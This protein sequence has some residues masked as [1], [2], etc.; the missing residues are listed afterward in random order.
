MAR[1]P[2]V[3]ALPP[4]ATARRTGTAPPQPASP[5]ASWL[6]VLPQSAKTLLIVFIVLGLITEVGTPVARSAA[7]DRTTNSLNVKTAAVSEW[8]NA[9]TTLKS[10]MAQYPT[11]NCRQSLSCYTTAD[12]HFAA[13]MS[14]FATQVQAIT[15]PPAAADD[16]N[17]VVADAKQA[18]QEFTQLSHVSDIGLYQ[19]TY[20][21][22][23]VA[24]E[25]QRFSQ[26]V[27]TFGTALG[28]S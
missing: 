9:F 17:T 14:T 18:A 11:N 6:L 2:P 20:S 15:M 19:G 25:L 7:A 21:G 16:A 8:N 22:L 27:A 3:T 23:G 13:A 10:D 26:D 28:N 12:S 1:L 24:T 5:P 4:P